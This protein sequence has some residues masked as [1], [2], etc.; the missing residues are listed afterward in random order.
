MDSRSR[1]SSNQY[2]GTCSTN[3]ASLAKLFIPRLGNSISE[4]GPKAS[5]AWPL[6]AGRNRDFGASTTWGSTTVLIG[7]DLFETLGENMRENYGGL[8][9]MGLTFNDIRHKFWE[10]LQMT[11]LQKYGIIET[12]TDKGPIS[13]Y[14]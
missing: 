14:L 7:G 11:A 1:P 12:M 5:R 2:V 10:T 3:W 4:L 13:H 9:F 6:E 8:Y